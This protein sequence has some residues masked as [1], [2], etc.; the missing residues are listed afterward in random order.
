MQ[1]KL[2]MQQKNPKI[3]LQL[4]DLPAGV[5]DSALPQ[6]HPGLYFQFCSLRAAQWD[7]P[8][9]PWNV[10][11]LEQP[12][13]VEGLPNH[14]VNFIILKLSSQR[15]NCKSFKV[16]SKKRNKNPSSVTLGAVGQLKSNFRKAERKLC[17]GKNREHGTKEQEQPP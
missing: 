1:G 12:G 9:D 16:P 5:Q 8:L 14:P 3:L 15:W 10:P 11:D 6:E 13:T 7:L 17:F 2:R 4:M